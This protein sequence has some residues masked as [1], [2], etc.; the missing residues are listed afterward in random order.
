MCSESRVPGVL[1]GRK[2]IFGDARML[3]LMRNLDRICN[4]DA[5]GRGFVYILHGK[6]DVA[7]LV[8][9]DRA[10]YSVRFHTFSKKSK[11]PEILTFQGFIRGENAPLVFSR[12]N[13]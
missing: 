10:D 3:I 13:V 11:S 2:K 9:A 5:R 12:N 4:E 8:V 1:P 6:R 7:R